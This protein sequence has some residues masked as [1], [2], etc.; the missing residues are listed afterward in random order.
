MQGDDSRKDNNSVKNS[1]KPKLNV[2]GNNIEEKLNIGDVI[3]GCEL[4]ELI[5]KGG[6]GAVFKAR[7]RSL[8]KSVAIKILSPRYWNDRVFIENFVTE[9]RIA[10]KIDHQN[11]VQVF[12]TGI[13]NGIPYILMQF[14]SG[15]TLRQ[16]VKNRNV[17]F[18]ELLDYFIQ[19]TKG[20]ISAHSQ[21]VVHR[22]IKPENLIITPEGSVK[23]TDFGLAKHEKDIPADLPK[24]GKIMASASFASSF[25]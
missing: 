8:D 24:N 16:V 17:P 4:L 9:A 3:G 13:D 18:S 19:T 22:D 12:D 5:G 6:M 23:I 20:L 25:P 11:V 1:Q 7:Q 14:V 15:K 21:K 10:A 2:N